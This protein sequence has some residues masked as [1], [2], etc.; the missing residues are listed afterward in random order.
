M[1]HLLINKS[2]T[3]AKNWRP[4]LL[5]AWMLIMPLTFSSLI[6]WKIYENEQ[7]IEGF[8]TIQWVIV[9][10]SFIITMAFA[11]TPTTVIALISGYFLGIMAIIPL[12]I[13]Y[14]LASVIGYIISKPLGKTF[15]KTV[16]QAY[17]K[18][19]TLVGRMSNYSQA[20]FVFFCRISPILP[21]AVMNVVLPFVGIKFKPFFWAGMAGMLPRTLLSVVAG[22]LA[23]NLFNLIKQPNSLASMQVGFVVLLTISI[24]GFALLLYR[25][26]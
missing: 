24:F 14:C 18:I 23:T 6:G 3:I 9:Y 8:S 16:H 7:I 20:G 17:P 5:M 12:V 25:K 15:H 21:F 4:F 19:D 13:T 10:V 22:S 2:K 11:L 26:K 1:F